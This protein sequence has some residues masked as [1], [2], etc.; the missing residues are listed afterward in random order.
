M[1]W[2]PSLGNTA[3]SPEVWPWSHRST[4]VAEMNQR[5]SSWR[6]SSAA[7]PLTSPWSFSLRN[8]QAG[9]PHCPS[10]LGLSHMPPP[11]FPTQRSRTGPMLHRASLS[12][13]Q[14]TDSST[15]PGPLGAQHDDWDWGT[16]CEGAKSIGWAPLQPWRPLCLRE[17]PAT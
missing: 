8:W 9:A 3:S 14:S 1:L 10:S 11:A 16:E 13:M 5:E 6:T 7:R 2:V 17:A 15:G 4:Q 12:S